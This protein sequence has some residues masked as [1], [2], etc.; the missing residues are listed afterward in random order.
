[1]D[2][3]G[4]TIAPL[5][6]MI[7]HH[8]SWT[9]RLPPEMLVEVASHLEGYPPLIAATH[10]CHLWRITLLSSP[11]LWSYLNFANE[12]RGLA[13]LERSKS[14]PLSVNLMG[15]GEPTK[16]VRESLKKITT[17]VTMLWATHDP[18][19]DELLAQSMPKLETME[20]IDSR[21]LT[22][23]KPT[24]LPSLKSLT[25]TGFDPLRFHAPILTS[26]HLTQESTVNHQGWTTAVLLNFLQNCPLLEVVYLCCDMHSDSDEFVSLPLLRS[27]T[28]ESLLD[29]Y[30]LCLLDRLSL[31]ST[32]LVV[33]VID[34]TEHQSNPWIPGL[35][36]PHDSSYLSDIRTVKI[37]AR[38]Y[39]Q[40]SDE[41]CLRFTIELVSSTRKAISF[42]R[43]SC[44]S[45]YP[46]F[47]SHEGFL[48]IFE[49]V[50]TGSVETLC[51]DRYPVLTPLAQ[52]QVTPEYIAQGL[53]NFRN[54]KTLILLDCDIILSLDGLASCPTIDT[55]IVHSL[56]FTD[57][58]GTS[59]INRVEV[60]AVSRKRAGS[61][62]RALTLVFP[63]A[64][65]LPLELI[66]R[67]ASCA[68]R[69]EVLSGCDAIF[70]E[71]DEYLLGAATHRDTT[72]RL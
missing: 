3:L 16:I 46:T 31:P 38:S 41:D 18:F 10:V 55:L 48:D 11:R 6:R 26:F 57:P 12:E 9:H 63:F 52:L 2:D 59:I 4:S 40:D 20:I 58:S 33:L 21:E 29:E 14:A 15:L 61:P 35:P 27:F 13:F 36:T 32:C 62:L 69:V 25:I 34:V 8:D 1:V 56:R 7:N 43:V 72:S 71:V 23:K 60:F 64:N 44:Y 50:E 19:L 54:L 68:G 70:W 66:E 24:H 30:Q 17:R 65:P 42:D 67:L 39:D 22:P 51:F 5:R 47:F 49:N 28:H 45:E 53:C 37:A